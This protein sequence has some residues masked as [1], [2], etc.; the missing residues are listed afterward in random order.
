M[1][2]PASASTFI[3]QLTPLSAHIRQI[4]HDQ[5][6]PSWKD[7]IVSVLPEV[8]AVVSFVIMVAAGMQ[9]LIAAGVACAG[10]LLYRVVKLVARKI[11]S[12]HAK[13]LISTK[14]PIISPKPTTGSKSK[15]LPTSVPSQSPVKTKPTIAA[16]EPATRSTIRS[17][18]INAQQQAQRQLD[19]LREGS[20]RIPDCY[21]TNKLTKG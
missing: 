3:P 13:P 17:H 14:A 4:N 11:Q 15:A 10:Y 9:P 20:F 7:R 21:V 2:A 18:V 1:P 5:S 6:R 16:Q 8:A 19:A 12:V